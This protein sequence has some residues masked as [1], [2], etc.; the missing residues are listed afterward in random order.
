MKCIKCGHTMEPEGPRTVEAEIR[1]SHVTV[2]VVAPAC[3]NCGRVALLGKTVRAYHR[4]VSDAYRQHVGLLTTQE[5]DRLR[6]DLRMTWKEFAEYVFVGIAT[7]KR[8]L[9]GEIQTQALDR[10]VRLR[11]DLPFLEKTASELAG[12][13]ASIG[14][15]QTVQPVKATIRPKVN[16]TD[17]PSS[18]QNATAA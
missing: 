5:L 9:R 3:P 8:W 14:V 10:L 11:A 2:S 18:N 12:R 13:L 15:M 17:S 16:W 1:G 4:A 6:C 7:L